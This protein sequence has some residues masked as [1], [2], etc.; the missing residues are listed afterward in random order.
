MR[1][2]LNRGWVKSRPYLFTL[3]GKNPHREGTIGSYRWKIKRNKT[4]NKEEQEIHDHNTKIGQ[5]MSKLIQ[6]SGD[7]RYVEGYHQ[8]VYDLIDNL[9]KP[10]REDLDNT[11]AYSPQAKTKI[12]ELLPLANYLRERSMLKIASRALWISALAVLISVVT[13]AVSIIV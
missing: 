12:D 6:E 8:L 9:P 11:Y 4:L 2:L 1:N 3:I 13:L 10:M 7:I 5:I